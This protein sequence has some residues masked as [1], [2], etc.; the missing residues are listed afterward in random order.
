[1]ATQVKQT[2]P[3][4][5]KLSDF[6]QAAASQ[7]YFR[8]MRDGFVSS[9]PF[10]VLA[11]LM[12][13]VN[14]VIISPDG[15][16]IA[17]LVNHDLLT[18]WQELGNKII[19]GSLN[20]YSLLIA[21]M[22]A[23]SL[24]S[25]RKAESPIFCSAVAVGTIFTLMPL[26]NEVLPNG[27]A[28]SVEVSG[29]LPFSLLGTSGI[30]VAIFAAMLS[31]ELF[32]WLGK[33]EKLKIKLTGTVPPAVAQSFNA[34]TAIMITLV[35]AGLV[36]FGIHQLTNLEVHALINKV[37]QA[38]MVGLTTSLPGFI[39]LCFFT[40]LLFALGI[41]PSGIVNP[42]LEPPLLA[43]M[44]ENSDA[45]KNHLD[46]PHIIVLPFRD[47]YGHIGGTGSTIALVIAI[48]IVSRKQFNRDFAKMSGPLGIFN[49]NEPIIYGFPV[50]FNPLIMI[51]FIFGPMICFI[52][53]YF[54][55]A[56]GLV[57]RIAVYVP[58][59]M[60]P[61]INGFVASG[62][63]VRNVILQ[64]LLIILMVTIY[65]PFLKSYELSMDDDATAV[66]STATGEVTADDDDFSDFSDF[67]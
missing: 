56:A 14:N 45:F 66:A 43:A 29:V 46:I 41:H 52:I 15:G 61:L 38:P 54:A 65:I 47:L 37:I 2:N 59:S 42:I 62:G 17:G 16:W 32:V 20:C 31:T 40:N 3:F 33:N 64:L 50:V 55:T 6:A 63:D 35:V 24:G 19:N 27:S 26:V 18:T 28:K 23:Y 60:P 49:I 9:V 44:A 51:P 36:S 22:I 4:L 39:V 12:I 7:R 25:S 8:A 10:L 67:K 53:A 21:I 58:W 11:G 13:L 30:F 48:F 1:M 34:L 5:K 57:S